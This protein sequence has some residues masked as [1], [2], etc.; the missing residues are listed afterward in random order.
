MQDLRNNKQPFGGPLILLAG[1]FRQTLPIIPKSTPVDEINAGLKSLFLWRH[2]KKSTLSTNMRFVQAKINVS[3][4]C[5]Y[6][7]YD[8]RFKCKFTPKTDHCYCI[9][10]NIHN[11]TCQHM[12]HCQ[13]FIDFPAYNI[14]CQCFI[15][16]DFFFFF[17]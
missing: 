7:L 8:F 14:L 3:E 11:N 9:S 16:P 5:L 1:D 17:W 15:I 2:V 13:S 6:H 4:K 10:N 12:F